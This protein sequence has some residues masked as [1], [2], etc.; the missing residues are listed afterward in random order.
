MRAYDPN[1]EATVRTSKLVR[2]WTRSGLLESAQANVL[3][4]DLRTELKRTNLILRIVLFGFTMSVLQSILGLVFLFITSAGEVV[5]G[6]AAIIVGL[7]AIALTEM[8]IARAKFYRFGVEEACAVLSAALIAGGL[9][10]I[11][12]TG[13]HTFPATAAV[14]MGAIAGLALY[15]RYGYLYGALIALACASALPFV[16]EFPW[17]LARATTAILLLAVFVGA[18]VLRRSTLEDLRRDEYGAIEAIAWLGLYAALNL[19]LSFDDV[20]FGHTYPAAFFWGTYIAVWILPI[21]GL[22]VAIGD[23]HRPMIWVNL[24]AALATLA[25]NKLYLGWPHHTWDPIL[26]G[27]LL[28]SVA[29]GVRRW[30]SAGPDG[31]RAGFTPRRILSS[32]KASL[33]LV[34][35]VAGAVQPGPT[36]HAAP[37]KFTPGGGASGGG[38]AT[39]NF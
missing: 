13:T 32:D 36:H 25:T 7:G 26:L 22:I 17:P 11:M 29:I 3:G 34:S 35:A 14:V 28:V 39:G 8:L 9:V 1:D 31:E 20:V 23:R 16:M 18:R 4:V 21:V 33:S 19:R 12:S 10:L 30:L 38:G 24:V 27:L 15:V 6:T 37:E 2:E 5:I